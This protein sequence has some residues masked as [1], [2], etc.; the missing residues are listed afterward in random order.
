VTRCPDFDFHKAMVW[1]LQEVAKADGI[2]LLP[3]WENSRGA[4]HEL[5]VAVA[6]GKRIFLYTPKDGM[7]RMEAYL[8]EVDAERVSLDRMTRNGETR[9]VDPETG[10][11][12]GSKLAQLGAL[13]P[14]ALL[15]VAKVA[16][17]GGK[18]YDRFNYA[19]GYAWSLTY[20]ALLR[21]LLAF[22]DGEEV[23]SESGLPHCAHAAWH[24]LALLTFSSRGLGTDDRFP[25]G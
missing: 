4:G 19:K 9:V 14:A 7:L 23:D 13:D 18:K 16:G 12:K 25:Q 15:E 11:A 8:T 22:L 10:G 5:D 17:F 1:D 24:C 21:H 3:G 6:C 20:D 2:V